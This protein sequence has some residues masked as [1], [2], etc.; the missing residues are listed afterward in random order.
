[1]CASTALLRKEQFESER[2]SDYIKNLREIYAVF[3]RIRLSYDEADDLT[4]NDVVLENLG[5][6]LEAIE[7]HWTALK[8]SIAP[9]HNL[10]D[11]T[12]SVAESPVEEQQIDSNSKCG[13]C[14]RNLQGSGSFDASN[15][16]NLSHGIDSYH[17]ACANF[18]VN[19]VAAALPALS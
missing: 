7:K 1:V 19:R 18:W 15:I 8:S 13:L 10:K 9:A 16:A 3:K 4:P 12:P 5:D 14:L 6:E 2:G 17:A 11:A